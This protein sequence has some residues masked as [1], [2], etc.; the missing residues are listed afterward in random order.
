MGV[1]AQS[2]HKKEAWD[3]L[4]WFAVEIQ[5]ETGRTRYGELLADTIG[6]IPTRRLDIKNSNSLNGPFKKVYVDQLA[7]SVPEPNVAEYARIKN[8]LR[9]YIES[10]WAGEVSAQMALDSAAL[11]INEILHLHYQ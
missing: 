2:P 8:I 7:H 9:V 5:P 6:A 4:R 1:M 3:F 10:A 11:K